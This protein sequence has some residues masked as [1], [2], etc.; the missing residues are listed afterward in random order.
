MCRGRAAWACSRWKQGCSF[1]VRFDQH[2]RILPEEEARL[3]FRTGATSVLDGLRLQDGTLSSGRIV[4][5]GIL[6]PYLSLEVGVALD[7]K[8]ESDARH[9]R[10]WAHKVA[11]SWWVQA[12][13]GGVEP[14]STPMVATCDLN[15]AAPPRAFMWLVKRHRELADANLEECA[16][17]WHIDTRA[18]V[19]TDGSP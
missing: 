9:A 2:G 16:K 17:R 10:A 6:E 18:E 11:A 12:A 5:V 15:T 7:S 4:L 19:P 8:Q 14:C 1:S 3:L 13:Q